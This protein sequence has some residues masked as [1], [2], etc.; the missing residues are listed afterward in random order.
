MPAN[1]LVGAIHNTKRRMPAILE[2]A[3]RDAWLNGTREQAWETLA[4]YPDDLIVAW[5]VSARV[6]APKN[7]DSQLIEP[8][9]A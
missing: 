4:P 9:A 3:D 2:K 1:S 8:I 5:P 6:N 7:N